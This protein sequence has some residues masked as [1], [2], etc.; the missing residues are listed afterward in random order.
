MIKHFHL[1]RFWF[2]P[3]KSRNALFVIIEIS[4]HTAITEMSLNLNSAKYSVLFLLVC[5][6]L[7]TTMPQARAD[8]I[9]L[10]S[11]TSTQNSGLYETILPLFTAQTG[12]GVHV[13]AVGTGK[14]LAN[15]RNCNGDVLLIHS[16]ADEI[17]FV[18]DGFG[19]YRKDVMYNDF[20]LI[21]PVDDPANIANANQ[22]KDALVRIA[23][24]QSSF[25]SRAD[26]SGTHKKERALWQDAAIDPSPASGTWYLE[27]GTGMGATLNLAVEK[28]AYVLS[29][30]ATWISF[31]NKQ[32]HAILF[33]GDPIL[34][35]Q[36]GI[37]PIAKSACPSSREDLAVQLA[38]WLLSAVGQEAIAAHKKA[39][40]QLFT[41]NAR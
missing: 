32:N 40:S 9:L 16:T 23:L 10:Q 24:S 26:D 41:P 15:G 22:L 31:A 18:Q 36:Y 2:I 33:S 4:R 20:V 30:R 5:C 27:T 19:L 37:V 3:Q 17:A 8:K 28:Q 6:A 13:V 14:A 7:M 38:D 29:D 35:N 25:A 1:T 12:I 11:T 34:F 21:G 39:G